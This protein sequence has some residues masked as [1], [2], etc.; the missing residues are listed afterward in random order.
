MFTYN[1]AA[2]VFTVTFIFLT[3]IPAIL[4]A[5]WPTSFKTDLEFT[6]YG[7]FPL[8]AIEDSAGGA[9]VIFGYYSWI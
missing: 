2:K 7:N 8:A 6:N 1:K 3:T 9:Y 5:Q 4:F